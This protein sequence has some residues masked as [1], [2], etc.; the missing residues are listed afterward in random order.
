[1]A[2]GLAA[3]LPTIGGGLPLRPATPT[4]GGRGC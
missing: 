4:T 2:G 1:M 3:L